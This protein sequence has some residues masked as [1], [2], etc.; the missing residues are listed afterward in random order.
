MGDID[1][2]LS[3]S[4]DLQPQAHEEEKTNSSAINLE[5][6]FVNVKIGDEND[7]KEEFNKKV[8]FFKTSILPQS[9]E[10]IDYLNELII[11]KEENYFC[12]D[13]RIY[14]STHALIWY[15]TFVC[16]NCA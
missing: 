13:C 4:S 10:L 2:G 16:Q 7:D 6:D 15:G 8:T 1:L 11:K 14:P 12:I 3:I 9:Q 5:D